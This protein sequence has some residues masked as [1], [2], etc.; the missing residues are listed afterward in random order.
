[1]F[2]W[3][4][5]FSEYLGEFYFYRPVREY[6]H[7]IIDKGGEDYPVY[8]YLFDYKTET[9]DDES[10]PVSVFKP[11]LGKFHGLDTMFFLGNCCENSRVMPNVTKEDIFVNETMATIVHKFMTQKVENIDLPRYRPE[12]KIVSRISEAGA[13]NDNYGYQHFDLSKE[14]FVPI[15]LIFGA[16]ILKLFPNEF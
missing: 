1:M 14:S 8:A 16:L 2:R 13:T 9:R 12:S 3:R 4:N 7:E 6:I 15:K 10:F 11:W 5:F